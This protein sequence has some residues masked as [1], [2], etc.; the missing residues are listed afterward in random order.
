MLAKE[1]NVMARSYCSMD[2]FFILK[3]APQY[4][5]TY[6]KHTSNSVRGVA[7]SNPYCRIFF[8]SQFYTHTNTYN[9]PLFIAWGRVTA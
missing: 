4:T 6:M 3:S 2:I 7:K 1:T 5:T 8:H 9:V